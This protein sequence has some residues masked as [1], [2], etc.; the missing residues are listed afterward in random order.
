MSINTRTVE[1]PRDQPRENLTV[2]N[3]G[4]SFMQAAVYLYIS[5]IS[6]Y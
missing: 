6:G 1:L 2:N 3:R 5:L 4:L